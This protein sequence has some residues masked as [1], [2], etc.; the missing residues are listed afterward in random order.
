MLTI[1]GAGMSRSPRR[2]PD[3]D[4]P[5]GPSQPQLDD[6]S[7]PSLESWCRKQRDSLVRPVTSWPGSK[8]LTLQRTWRYAPRRCL[9]SCGLHASVGPGSTSSEACTAAAGSGHL[10]ILKWLRAQ[11]CPWDTHTFQQARDNREHRWTSMSACALLLQLKAL[12]MLCPGF[13]TLVVRG[14]QQHQQWHFGRVTL[15]S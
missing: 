11:D 2:R 9:A 13:G 14:T 3:L 4:T 12:W 7:T 6:D 1:Q 5:G 15:T 10:N 8:P